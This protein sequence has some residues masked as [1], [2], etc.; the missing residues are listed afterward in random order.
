M[1]GTCGGPKMKVTMDDNVFDS[2]LY[3][4]EDD[5]VI[6]AAHGTGT[7]T[8]SM[9]LAMGGLIADDD[10]ENSISQSQR[11]LDTYILRICVSVSQWPP[12]LN[13]NIN[14]Y[15]MLLTM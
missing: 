4:D 7:G 5:I 11:R 6:V 13:I 3:D 10:E 14:T 1:K 12:D 8:M 9:C 15:K 2:K